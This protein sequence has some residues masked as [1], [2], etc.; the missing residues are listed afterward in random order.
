MVYVS[1]VN[2]VVLFFY[3]F[4]IFQHQNNDIHYIGDEKTI[5]HNRP[6]TGPTCVIYYVATRKRMK[7]KR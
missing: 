1:L 4:F 3:I 7:Y 6:D 5:N 2:L